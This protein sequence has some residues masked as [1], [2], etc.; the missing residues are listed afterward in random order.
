M[1]VAGILFGLVAELL[2][3]VR[4]ELCST[5][6]EVSGLGERTLGVKVTEDDTV[7]N[8]VELIV[9]KLGDKVGVGVRSALVI[10]VGMAGS[11]LNGVCEDGEL[12]QFLAVAALYETDFWLD[13]LTLGFAVLPGLLEDSSGERATSVD[14]ASDKAGVV[15][16]VLATFTEITSGDMVAMA[17][18]FPPSVLALLPTI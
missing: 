16:L 5:C 18:L 10:V 11:P 15:V 1:A 13:V 7:E 12:S 9:S 14:L 3:L 17:I 4:D 8:T 2:L 6:K